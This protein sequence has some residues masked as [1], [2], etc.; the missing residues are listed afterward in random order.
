VIL[1]GHDAI[2]VA[3]SGEY[4]L[5]DRLILRELGKSLRWTVLD[6]D[7]E[8]SGWRATW[9]SSVAEPTLE[10]SSSTRTQRALSR[11]GPIRL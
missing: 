7:K 9:P 2:A 11:S 5:Y 1:A 10:A 3:V 8:A 6:G 4:R